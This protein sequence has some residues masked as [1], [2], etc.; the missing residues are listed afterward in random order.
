[1]LNNIEMFKVDI[2]RDII[3]IHKSYDLRAHIKMYIVYV[4]KYFIV[5]VDIEFL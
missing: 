2:S 4:I 1:M 5:C 3:I